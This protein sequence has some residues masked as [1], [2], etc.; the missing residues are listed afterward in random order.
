MYRQFAE[1]RLRRCERVFVGEALEYDVQVVIGAGRMG[2]VTV[3]ESTDRTFSF[4]EPTKIN[5]ADPRQ[6]WLHDN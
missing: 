2:T 1:Q 4:G 6:V 5:D 3:D